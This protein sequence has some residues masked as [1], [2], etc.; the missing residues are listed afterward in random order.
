MADKEED[1]DLGEGEEGRGGKKKLIIFAGIGW[2]VLLLGGGGA[3]FML[4]GGNEEALA[5]GEDAAEAIIE[6][7]K[8]AVYHAL[9]PAFVVNFPGNSK[10]RFLQLDLEVMAR[11]EEAIAAVE[12][13]SPMIRNNLLMLFGG[14]DSGDLRTREGKE[15]LRADVLAELQ[16]ILTDETGEPGVEQVFFT[17]FVM[18]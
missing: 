3:F 13:H 1:V 2:L 17:S 8:M 18:Q 6:E 11:S 7:P 5:G 4:S 10:H 15:K 14:T 9:E 16:K 12:Q